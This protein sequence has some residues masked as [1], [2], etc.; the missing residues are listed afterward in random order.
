[1]IYRRAE[2]LLGRARLDKPSPQT[3]S[4]FIVVANSGYNI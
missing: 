3:S 2:R 4:P 1:M